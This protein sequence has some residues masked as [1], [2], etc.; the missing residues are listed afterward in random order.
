LVNISITPFTRPTVRWFIGEYL[1]SKAV[2]NKG[3]RKKGEGFASEMH[4]A[5]EQVCIKSGFHCGPLTSFQ[6][7]VRKM[8][9]SGVIERTR[10]EQGK[11]AMPRQYFCLT[12]EFFDAMREE[13][14]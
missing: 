7:E 11:G 6:R 1:F 3:N 9:E 2:E 5:W 4:R 10:E 14:R 13:R 8:L 12:K